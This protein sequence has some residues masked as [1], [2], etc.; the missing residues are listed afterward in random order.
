MTIS[1]DF[2]DRLGIKADALDEDIR[3]AY[4]EAVRR[5]HPDVN[6][7]AGA[8]ELFLDIREAYEVLSDPEKR[9]I[10]DGTSSDTQ[11]P[12]VQTN[13]VYSRQTVSWLAE[14]QL[15]YV[16]I[17][18]NVLSDQLEKE[19][20]SS[21]P[22]N[23]A[24]VLDCSTSMQGARLDVVKASAI[25]IIREL[26][27]QDVL[28]IIAF[29]DRAEVVLPAGLYA[30]D[31]KS[32][33][34]IRKLQAKGGTEIFQGL[35]AG[36]AEV[37][38]NL[39]PYYINHVILI[40]DGHTYGDET[41]CQE[42]AQKAG[43][44]EIGI[45]CLGIGTGWNDIFLDDLSSAT[46]GTS[47]YIHDLRDISTLLR[48]KFIGLGQVNIDAISLNLQ[49]GAGIT[50]NY[51]YRMQPEASVFPTSP[52]MKLGS[53][54][55][56]A[57]LSILLEFI[58]SP[59][60]PSVMKVLI[61]EGSFTFSVPKLGQ[62][63]YRI[64]ITL[65]RPSSADSKPEPPPK[66]ILDSMSRLTLYRMQEQARKELESGEYNQASTRLQNMAT[67]LFSTGEPELAKTV[68]N[69]VQNIQNHKK[70]SKE[71]RKQIKFGTRALISPPEKKKAA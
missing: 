22:I 25:E 3:R 5:L 53:I 23:I 32:E 69:E 26:R 48:D 44:Q 28:S 55:K 56:G 40:T 59:I 7:E 30:N 49:T 47:F 68:L 1:D 12:P 33:N 36:V 50:L 11:P 65:S 15:V 29:N 58:I 21:P 6:K 19:D 38:R 18:L 13:I 45:S 34:R 37:Q 27:P 61:A 63:T 16:L 9:S 57:H 39:S 71:G 66:E 2:Y 42:L 4:R 54:S 64:P 41:N 70:Y 35:N 8:T 20:E 24:L 10:Y 14:K 17:D 43:Q 51:A 46:G 31:Q 67:H 52:P 62:T 60:P